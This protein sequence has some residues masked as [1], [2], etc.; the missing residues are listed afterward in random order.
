MEPSED[1]RK[2][3][4]KPVPGVG[5]IVLIHWDDILED[6]SWQDVEHPEGEVAKCQS[7]GYVS[8]WNNKHVVLVRTHKLQGESRHAGDRITFPRSVVTKWEV[9]KAAK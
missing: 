1:K 3:V 5:D 9:L 2:R 4:R 8:R 6:P 7:I